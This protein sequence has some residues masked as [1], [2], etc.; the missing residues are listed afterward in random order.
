MTGSG[1]WEDEGSRWKIEERG[2]ALKAGRAYLQIFWRCRNT[3]VVVFW[4]SLG[5]NIRD[6]GGE[7]R[8]RKG[9]P[10]TPEKNLSTWES[11]DRSQRGS[12]RGCGF[13]GRGRS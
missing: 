11:V 5:T 9:V 8:K 1:N 12:G 13:E 2:D 7:K 3:I 10:A 6:D 4:R